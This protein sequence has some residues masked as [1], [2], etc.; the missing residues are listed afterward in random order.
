MIDALS[1]LRGQRGFTL[2][3]LMLSQ[4]LGLLLISALTT[5]MAGLYRATLISADAT[6]TTERAYYIVDALASWINQAAAVDLLSTEISVG[7]SPHQDSFYGDATVCQT[8]VTY[9]LALS[10]PGVRLVQMTDVPCV[11]SNVGPKDTVALLLESRQRC[12]DDCRAP[13][14]YLVLPPCHSD[15]AVVQWRNSGALSDTLS[16]TLSGVGPGAC[17]GDE[18]VYRLER[19]IIYIRDYSWQS[20]DNS[21]ALMMTT[22]APEPDARWLRSIM[23]AAE[24][25]DWSIACVKF[26]E[27]SLQTINQPTGIQLQ[28]R[29]AGRYQSVSIA[30]HILLDA[31]GPQSL[32]GELAESARL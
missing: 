21:P 8:P 5:S 6:E 7:T 12:H 23:L 13:G 25:F 29:A 4:A 30:R 19:R 3:G 9:P 16:G 32:G 17:S 1:G 27:H 11:R 24:I 26:C 20:G 28:F 22:L 31:P 2:V 14:F 18:T 10:E 15:R